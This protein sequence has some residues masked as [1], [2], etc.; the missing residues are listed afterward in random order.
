MQLFQTKHNKN[1]YN[2][3]ERRRAMALATLAGG[4]FWCMVQ[5]FAQCKGVR[6]V[7]V[8]YT[9]G[10]TAHPTYAAVCTGATGH[11]EAARIAFDEE[12]ISF[13]QL[14]DV[15]WRNIDPTDAH[16]QFA[17]RGSMYESVIFVH[18]EEQHRIACASKEALQHSGVFAKPI[19]TRIAPVQPFYEAEP[20]HQQYCT[21]NPQHYAAYRIGSGRA[22]FIQR[23]WG[24]DH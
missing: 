13:G 17:D 9:G 16:G 20:M 15:Y 7:V 23:V 3:W 1:G 19:V 6:S 5:P 14:L 4:C 22:G 8:G 2:A 10:H 18:D 24:S 11:V 12:H 21:K